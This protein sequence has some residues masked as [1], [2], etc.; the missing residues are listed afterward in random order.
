MFNITNS[1]GNANFKDN[2]I[3]LFYRIGRKFLNWYIQWWQVCGEMDILLI[4]VGCKI[5]KSLFRRIWPY[6]VYL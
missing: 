3:V 6:F 1:Q 2:K 4:T 5:G